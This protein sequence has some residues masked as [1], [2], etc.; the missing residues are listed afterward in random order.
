M[1]KMMMMMMMTMM[2]HKETGIRNHLRSWD[3]GRGGV[4]AE[5]RHV[6]GR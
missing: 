6:K 3:A 2:P 1:I 5:E 4:L